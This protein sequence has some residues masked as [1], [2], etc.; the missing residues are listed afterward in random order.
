MKMLVIDLPPHKQGDILYFEVRW[1]GKAVSP[2]LR[3]WNL[4]FLWE[5]D[6]CSAKH[7]AWWRRV[8]DA[9]EVVPNP[10]LSIHD[11]AAEWKANVICGV[12]DEIPNERDQ[13][14]G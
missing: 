6:S 3:G 14:K 5:W 8:Q 4:H 7:Y 2:D 13:L 11:P 1:E 9:D 12:S 10:I